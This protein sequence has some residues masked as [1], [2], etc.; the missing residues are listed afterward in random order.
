[1][2]EWF[3]DDMWGAI[4]ET[5]QLF[6]VL[7][8]AG[9]GVGGWF[10]WKRLVLRSEQRADDGYV[11]ADGALRAL[12]GSAGTVVSALRPAGKA[13]IDGKRVDVV[14]DSEFIARDTPVTVVAVEGGRVV[15]RPSA[16]LPTHGQLG[17]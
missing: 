8:L 17:K 1:M 4:V 10:I 9:V 5:L 7:M 6:G 12:V 13:T 15:V 2:M 11:A 14:S 3:A 16:E